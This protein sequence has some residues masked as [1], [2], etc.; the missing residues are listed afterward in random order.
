MRDLEEKKDQEPDPHTI[1]TDEEFVVSEVNRISISKMEVRLDL[2]DLDIGLSPNCLLNGS[3]G[4]TPVEPGNKV[5]VIGTFSSENKWR[6]K[7][8]DHG[9]GPGKGFLFVL[10]PSILLNSTTVSTSAQC[11]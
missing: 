2:P 3:W 1:W 10:E 9:P 4:R 6:L 5:R 7:F 8:D 11:V